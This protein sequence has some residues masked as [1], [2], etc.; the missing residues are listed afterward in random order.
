MASRT[1]CAQWIKD[2]H[3]SLSTLPEHDHQAAP[4]SATRAMGCTLVACPDARPP[5]YQAA[6]GLS[7]AG[8]LDRF[9]TAAYYDREGVIP[10]LA[11]RLLPI[12]FSRWER[13]LQR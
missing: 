6:A 2:D 7:Q 13:V 9:V 5:A 4:E 8:R 12:R 10:I 11:R 1:R 3:V